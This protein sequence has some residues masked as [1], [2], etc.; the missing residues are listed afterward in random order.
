MEI[1]TN[2]TEHSPRHTNLIRNR[3]KYA[4]AQVYPLCISFLFPLS[5]LLTDLP[6]P[7]AVQQVSPPFPSCVF[8][9]L[10][11]FVSGFLLLTIKKLPIWPWRRHNCHYY[12]C[13]PA[14]HTVY[15]LFR[16]G[17][18]GKHCLLCADATQYYHSVTTAHPHTHARVSISVFSALSVSL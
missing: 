11:P 4:N 16:R 18:G 3:Y 12:C 6:H 13:G 10:S 7:A 14:H 9:L 1:R 15:W 5:P 2:W 17:G 8:L